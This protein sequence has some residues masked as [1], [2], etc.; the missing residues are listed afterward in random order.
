MRSKLRFVARL[1]YYFRIGYGTYLTFLLSALNTLIVIWYLA[2]REVPAI[3]NFFGHF[4][5][6][7]AVAALIGVPLSIATGWA[8]YKRSPAFTSESEIQAEANPFN[9]KLPPGYWTEVLVPLYL[10]LLQ[11]V[12]KLAEA[13]QVLDH[14]DIPRIEDL[15]RKLETLISGGQVGTPR[16]KL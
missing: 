15:E 16:R 3:E 6:F 7:A 2:I 4:L 12:K 1:W 8:H 11:Q 10:Q 14:K 13:Q 9:Y 5:P